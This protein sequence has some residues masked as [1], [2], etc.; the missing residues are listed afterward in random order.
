MREWIVLVVV[1]C[2]PHKQA[3]A[4]VEQGSAKS[5]APAVVPVRTDADKL[6]DRTKCAGSPVPASSWLGRWDG[7]RPVDKSNSFAHIGPT[8]ITITPAGD[9]LHV[10]ERTAD[11]Q[12]DLVL[13]PDGIVAR[14]QSFRVE[15]TS[16]GVKAISATSR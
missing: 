15:H 3:P 2:A 12:V 4:M 16:W 11:Y 9:K 5:P 10:A 1:G 6:V 14:G 7:T 8:R 13:D